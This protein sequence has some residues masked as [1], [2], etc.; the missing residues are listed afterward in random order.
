MPPSQAAIATHA[1][2]AANSKHLLIDPLH[3]AHAAAVGATLASFDGYQSNHH[4]STTAAKEKLEPVQID[5]LGDKAEASL[6]SDKAANGRI[7]LTW[8]T[9]AS[10]ETNSLDLCRSER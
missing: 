7:P 6:E 1:L 10:V 3:S 5:L 9:G 8:E 2:R 4:K